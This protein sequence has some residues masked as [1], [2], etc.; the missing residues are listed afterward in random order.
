[1]ELYRLTVKVPV[2]QR[3]KAELHQTIMKFLASFQ[4]H[5]LM[6]PMQNSL[7]A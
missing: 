6:R 2:H 4:E 3:L 1:M 7:V 5:L